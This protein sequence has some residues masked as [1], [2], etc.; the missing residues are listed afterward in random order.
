MKRLITLLLAVFVVTQSNAQCPVTITPTPT[1][2]CVGATTTLT[3]AG[4]T[5]YTWSSNAGGVTTASVAVTPLQNTIYT[6]TATTGTC[7]A[8]ETVAIMVFSQPVLTASASPTSICSGGTSTLTASGATTYTWNTGATTATVAVTPTVYT[9]YTVTASNGVCTDTQVVAVSIS[10]VPNITVSATPMSV[11]A[12]GTATLSASGANTYTWSANAGGGT[13]P[14]AVVTPGA[15]TTYTVTGTN[16]SGCTATQTVTVGVNPFLSIAINAAPT[17]VCNGGTSTLTASGASS[18]TWS[19]NAGGVNTPTTTVNPPVTTVYTVTG[20]S[21][22]CI[23]TQTVTVQVVNTIT[24]SIFPLSATVCAGS[25]TTLTASGASSYTWSPGNATTPTL[26]LTPQSSSVYTVTGSSGSCT[27]SQTVAVFTNAVP[28][29]T[30]TASPSSICTGGATSTLTASGATSYTWSQNAGSATTSSVVVNPG[31]STVYTVTGSNGTCT[32]TETVAVNVTPTIT[33]T[34]TA[35]PNGICVGG[36]STLTASGAATY[37]WSANAGNVNTPSAVVSPTVSDTY[38][39]T[40]ISGQCVSSQIVTVLI[41]P[42]ITLTVTANP[43]SICS[44]T[45]ST[46]TAYGASTY[47]WSA[48]AGSVTTQSVVVTPTVNTTYTVTASSGGCSATETVAVAVNPLPTVTISPPLGT[49]TVV[50]TG[51]PYQFN[52][53]A[54]PGPIMYYQWHSSGYVPGIATINIANGSCG[55]CNGPTIT[56]NTIGPDTLTLITTTSIGCVDSIKYA[57]SVAPTPTVTTGPVTPAPHVCQGGTGAILYAYGATTYTWTPLTNILVYGSGDSVL[58]NPPNVGIYTYS[59]TGTLGACTS[60]PVAI[61][62]TVDPVPTPSL[63][64][65]PTNDSICSRSSGHFYV[66]NLP[67]NTTYTWTQASINVGLGTF[68]GSNTSITP[69]YNGTVDTTFTAQVNFTVPGCPAYPTYTM[70]IVVVPTPTITVVSDT[71]DNCNG[72]GDSLEVTCLPTTG[73]QYFWTPTTAMTPTTGVGNPVFVNPTTEMWYYCTPVNVYLGCI[74]DK[75]SVLVRIG[76]TTYADITAQYDIIC[77]GMSDTLIASP[78]W[79]AL[80]STYQYYWTGG[81][82]TLSPIGDIFVVSPGLTT[83]YTLT[84]SG[85]C[86]K[87]KSAEYTIY[88]NNCGTIIPDFSVTKDTICVNQCVYYTDLTNTSTVLPLF[89]MWVFTGGNPVGVNGQYTVIADT[90]YYAATDSTPVPKIKVCYPINSSLNPGGVFPVYQYVSHSPGG[91][92]SLVTHYIK[93][94]PGPIANAGINVSITLGDSIQLNGTNSTGNFAITTYSWS[95]PDSL[96][97]IPPVPPLNL[98]NTCAQPWAQ[99]SETTT[100]YLTVTDLN[101]C[102][103]TDSMI[104]YVDNKCFEPFVPSGFSP[105]GDQKNDMLFVRSNCLQN[106]VFKV[107][108][109]WGEMVFETTDLNFGWD[110]TWRGSPCNLGVFAWTLEGFMLNG[111]EVKKHGTTT[112]IR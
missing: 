75:D 89:Y 26:T 87:K 112:L 7:V 55:N 39:V 6:V 13:G 91:P 37:T 86:V 15:T 78:Q 52:G 93:V 83:T 92:Q 3:A 48:N 104:V 67:P 25:T 35:N 94:D 5:T 70:S 80:N 58:V 44:G 76:D 16:S 61:T 14:N 95:P 32:S 72:M 57:V 11:C 36:T 20:S 85:T 82:G 98:P 41:L 18:Y 34:T 40:G 29:I 111:K 28:I 107:Y 106:F 103:H 79:T 21:G 23:A 22:T 66:Y 109:R 77:S 45:T 100:Y 71:V 47:T 46:L 12:G 105:N 10:P 4:G 97:C 101:G 17:G 19:A 54:N 74:G 27:A 9:T 90:A 2:V 51:T 62:I 102:K 38:T 88:V 50:C 99:P 84:V 42:S 56:F 108:N 64:V 31:I 49:T 30:A 53:N 24:V 96:H 8:T 63:V 43:P 33:I 68:S 110:G 1:S 60:L 73:S 81:T 65:N 69:Y 59:V